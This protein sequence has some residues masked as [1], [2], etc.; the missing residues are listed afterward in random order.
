MVLNRAISLLHVPFSH[1]I[2]R[3]NYLK[4]VITS[5]FISQTMFAQDS[6]T[7]SL[8]KYAKENKALGYVYQQKELALL[9]EVGDVV[10]IE[11]LKLMLVPLKSIVKGKKEQVESDYD[12]IKS[13]AFQAQ[14]D[15]PEYTTSIEFLD[16]LTFLEPDDSKYENIQEEDRISVDSKIK[17]FEVY[18]FVNML[19][20]VIYEETENGIQPIQGEFHQWTKS[21][22]NLKYG[23]KLL[24]TLASGTTSRFLITGT[25]NELLNWFETQDEESVYPNDIFRQSYR[26]NNGNIYL[27][28][29]TIENILSRYHGVPD[30]ENIAITR[31]L[32]DI[33]N[34]HYRQDK[35]GTT[36]HLWGISLYGYVKG[37]FRAKLIARLETMSVKIVFKRRQNKQK[38][39]INQLGAEVGA[40]LKKTIKKEW[41]NNYESNSIYTSPS[42]YLNCFVRADD[43]EAD[44]SKKLEKAKKRKN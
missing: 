11:Y 14:I 16:E 4:I 34:S 35:Y 18:K 31:K 20:Q 22:N 10:L 23:S 37:N 24:V 38:R 15:F 25:E 32:A 30:R 40:K 1:I 41:I 28:V 26:I 7:S 5:F 42:Y 29:L 2:K 6:E 44:L 3:S 19:K 12:K 39:Q 9:D 8:I 33:T 43:I 17:P 13:M 36:Y 21:K 27:S